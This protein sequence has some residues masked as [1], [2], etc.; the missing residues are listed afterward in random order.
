MSGAACHFSLQGFILPIIQ[1]TEQQQKE[2]ERDLHVMIKTSHF[3]RL[4]VEMNGDTKVL[5]SLRQ[6]YNRRARLTCNTTTQLSKQTN[7]NECKWISIW[8]TMKQIV[9]VQNILSQVKKEHTVSGSDV[10]VRE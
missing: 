1:H 8:D 6:M 10:S 3:H 4:L 7:R 2:R 5:L 9:A